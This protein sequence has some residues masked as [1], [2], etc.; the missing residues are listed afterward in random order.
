M[1][2]QQ[3]VQVDVAL[4]HEQG[5][6]STAETVLPIQG[7]PTEKGPACDEDIASVE[8]EEVATPDGQSDGSMTA[9]EKTPTVQTP[10]E[11][12]PREG[13][14]TTETT[15]TEEEAPAPEQVKEV[16]TETKAT[17][18]KEKADV[19]PEKVAQKIDKVAN[20]I[21]QE[22]DE[23][24]EEQLEN[25]TPTLRRQIEIL[26]KMTKDYAHQE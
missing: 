3:P 13:T 8:S 10:T 19:I 20:I 23:L 11:Q 6:W 14:L 2:A 5:S 9:A 24:S 22:L 12:T 26:R 7:K 25:L 16:G 15:M 18:S 1:K 4:G 21:E 17:A